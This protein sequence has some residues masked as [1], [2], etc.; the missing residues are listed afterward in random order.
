VEKEEEEG[1]EEVETE[2]EEEEEMEE[3]VIF[4]ISSKVA[5][6]IIPGRAAG[7]SEAVTLTC[8]T[9]VGWKEMT[10]GF[11]KDRWSRPFSF[12]L[13]PTFTL[14]NATCRD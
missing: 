4:A 11:E 10:L 9:L 8:M 3:E 5:D 6:F 13:P 14:Q 2:P 7:M 12:F 1:I